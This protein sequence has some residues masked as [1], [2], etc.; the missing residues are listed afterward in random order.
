MQNLIKKRPSQSAQLTQ[1][2]NEKQ[3]LQDGEKMSCLQALRLSIK[4]LLDEGLSENLRHEET[5][6]FLQLLEIAL[7]HGYA[8]NDDFQ[9]ENGEQHE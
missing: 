5:Q 3:R 6:S 8:Y 1:G 4:Y 2:I 9:H 7:R